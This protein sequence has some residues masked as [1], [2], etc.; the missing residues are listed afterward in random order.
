MLFNKLLEGVQVIDFDMRYLY[1]NESVAKQ[2][3]VTVDELLG[4]RMLDKFPS[5]ADSDVYRKIKLCMKKR[6]ACNMINKFEH[7]DGSIAWFDLRIEPVDDGVIIFSLDIT[8]EKQMEDDLVS[9]NSGIDNMVEKRT[10]EL[11]ES[12]EREREL[13]ELKT[14][15]V[16]IASHQFRTPLTSII[17]SA[18]LVEQYG[19]DLM[20]LEKL[21]KHFHRI[22]SSATHLVSVLNDFLDLDQLES[23]KLHYEPVSVN[24]KEYVDD[25]FDNLNPLCKKNQQLTLVHSPKISTITIDPQIMKSVLLNLISNAIKYSDE[26]KEIILRCETK[27]HQLVFEVIDQ[28]MGIPEIEQENLFNK[29]YRASNARE[30]QGSGLGLNIVK[31][32]V[33]LA[34]GTIDFSSIENKGSVFRVSLPQYN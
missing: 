32:Y 29:F 15:F 33:E 22:K 24:L 11:C 2:V 19:T 31:Q 10:R 4:Q 18:S 13:N 34:Q 26:E 16:S 5:L 28:G 25:L 17:L 1:V 6:Q 8:H 27:S 23:K 12:L 9:M 3:M 7:L 30:I 20:E 21:N 14:K